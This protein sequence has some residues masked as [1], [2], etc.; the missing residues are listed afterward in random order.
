[1][2]E[3]GRTPGEAGCCRAD[4]FVSC[5]PG[6]PFSRMTRRSTRLSPQDHPLYKEFEVVCEYINKTEPK[7]CLLE[8]VNKL[9][10]MLL[11]EA[12]GNKYHIAHSMVDQT[13]WTDS[14]RSREF[15]WCLHKDC[16]SEEVARAAG[17]LA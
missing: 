11:R 6:Q 17:N 10:M 4:I 1:M 16:G 9:S 7:T 2:I 12:L 3:H 5:L 13:D 15:I 8:N 14:R